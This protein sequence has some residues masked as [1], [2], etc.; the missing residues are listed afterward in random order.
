[1]KFPKILLLLVVCSVSLGAATAQEAQRTLTNADIVKMTKSGIGEQTI[2]LLIERSG[3]KFDTSPDALIELK[4]EGVSDAVLNV[5][6]STSSVAGPSADG[7]QPDCTRLLDSALGFVGPRQEVVDIHSVRLSGK[8]IS[9]SA[10]RTSSFSVERVTVF[11]S[12]IYISLQPSSGISTK[13]VL[14]PELNYL[15]SGKMTT[16]IPTSTIQELRY[17]MKLE[18]IYISQHRDQYR[19]VLEG[20]EQIGNLSTA[21][22]KLK[23][24]DAEGLWNIDPATGR[25][26]RIAFTTSSSEQYFTDLSEWRQV[27]GLNLPFARHTVKDHTTND[28]TVSEYQVNPVVDLRLFQAPEQPV[29]ALTLKVRQSESVPYVVQTNGGIST[30]CNISGSTITSMNSSAYGNTSYGTATSTPNLQMNCRSSDTQ[31]AGLM[32]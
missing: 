17:E 30:A 4:K 27:D 9:H 23:G 24:E 26:L 1:M 28:L 22:L 18:P 2:V 19:C 5:M 13:A 21:K 20:T 6:L 11:P 8:E 12:S 32:C 29:A 10:S 7:P 15:T 3:S 16:S 14:T 25:L 31:F